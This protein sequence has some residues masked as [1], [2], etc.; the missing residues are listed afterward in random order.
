VASA[1]AAGQAS[2]TTVAPESPR[3][4]ACQSACSTAASSGCPDAQPDVATCVT[5]CEA[6]AAGACGEP[7]VRYL[8]C[9]S[10]GGEA[11]CTGYGPAVA[12]CEDLFY[13]FIDCAL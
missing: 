8:T 10:R 7:F 1:G 11:V 9:A 12:G 5:S 13:L 3:T 2:V 6:A 4:L